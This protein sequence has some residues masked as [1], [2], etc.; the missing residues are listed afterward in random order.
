[1][2]HEI[3][4]TD[5]EGRERFFHVDFSCT[6]YDPGRS[7]GPPE[8]CYPPEGGE[9]EV[10]WADEMLEDGRRLPVKWGDV[11]D[12][13]AKFLD[14]RRVEDGQ[15]EPRWTG[16]IGL[17]SDAESAAR[18]WLEEELFSVWQEQADDDCGPDPDT[19]PGGYDDF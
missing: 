13:Y 11:I 12:I 17:K 5:A 14:G 2:Q 3:T 10:K 19:A 7:S 8:L 4:F 16:H 15:F 9:V 18:T 1:M 6:P